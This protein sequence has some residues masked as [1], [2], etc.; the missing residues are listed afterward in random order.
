VAAR[1]RDLL[2][3]WFADLPDSAKSELRGNF[4]SDDDRQ[5]WGAFFELY[6]LALLVHQGFRVEVHKIA[7]QSKSTRPDYL[8]LR[9]GKPL[10]YMECTIAAESDKDH[11]GQNILNQVYDVLDRMESPNFF[12]G[13]E[14]RRYPPHPLSPSRMRAFL[15]RYLRDLDPDEIAEKITAHGLESV[16]HW[17]WSD[18]GW[19]I[20][21]YPIP[22]SKEHRN[23][24][25]ARPLGAQEYIFDHLDSEA[26][27]LRAIRSK[28]TR[29]GDLD[30]P[31]IVAVDVMDDFAHE[32]DIVSALFGSDLSSIER[33][34][35]GRSDHAPP[36]GLWI[37]P[38]G[39]QNKRV[40]AILTVLNLEIWTVG[41]KKPVLWLNPWASKEL[42]TGLWEG[43]K[44]RLDL[45]EKK[46]LS[47]EGRNAWEI[48]QLAHNWPYDQKPLS[49]IWAI[50][51]VLRS[52][53]KKV[54][55]L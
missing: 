43:P 31:Y 3:K 30:Y 6:S 5:H 38:K 37:G 42:E 19:E 36:G 22:K 7:D 44:R 33:L 54:G 14:I 39:P 34:L 52:L 20:V 50:L 12:I 2:E 9:K 25:G 13:T 45:A 23:K 49:P 32:M 47:M 26:S 11:A 1:A 48:L 40:S 28:A 55:P 51:S 17:I 15:E 21:F 46:V 8:V 53:Y 41:A 35:K 27:I 16:P 18:N 24:P 4:R 10:F 29:Y